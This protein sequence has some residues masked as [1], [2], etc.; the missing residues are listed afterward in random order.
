MSAPNS[1]FDPVEVAALSPDD[2][3][4]S[5]ESALLA[6]NEASDLDLLKEA[7]LAHAGDRSPLS[8]ANREIG[9]LPPAAKAEA[10]KRVGEARQQIKQALDA[11]A[12]ELEN[13]RDQRVLLQES[14]DVT[15]PYDRRPAGAPFLPAR[16][17]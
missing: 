5:V 17:W 1:S 9:A 15:L 12:V 2:I 3:A 6:I 11:R 14:V 10:G 16:A 7:R 8:L 4:A 13:E